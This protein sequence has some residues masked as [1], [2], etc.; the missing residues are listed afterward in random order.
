MYIICPN[1]NWPQE[2]QVPVKKEPLSLEELLAR[3][4]AEEARLKKPTFL[5]KEERAKIALEKRKKQ[6]RILVF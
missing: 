2:A 4:N 5:N 3:K 1:Y 6:V